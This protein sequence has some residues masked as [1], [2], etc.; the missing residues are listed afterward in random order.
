M[1]ENG[2]IGD[3][4]RAG[5]ETMRSAH[6]TPLERKRDTVGALAIVFLV[7]WFALQI[8]DAL[9]G[10]IF[11]LIPGPLGGLTQMAYHVSFAVYWFC[12]AWW[13]Y[14]DCKVRDLNAAA[15]GL[16]T[17]AT[18]FIGFFTYLVVRAPAARP[19]SACGRDLLPG[20]KVCPYCGTQVTDVCP[21]CGAFVR[22]DWRFCPSC[23]ANMNGYARRSRDLH[24]AADDLRAAGR[25]A[26]KAASDAA[27][28]GVTV[29][30]AGFQAAK[31]TYQ[32]ISAERAPSRDSISG[33]VTD[34][35]TGRPIAGARVWIDSKELERSATTGL[36]GDYRLF[37]LE[38]GPYVVVA[39]AAGYRRVVGSCEV[40]G[41]ACTPLD[42]RLAKAPPEPSSEA[43]PGQEGT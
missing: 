38:P 37:G 9:P 15:W 19:C 12:L 27:E 21:E 30:R 2:G 16:L 28:I 25:K 10:D 42:F 29:A 1:S 20:Q 8:L 4:L 5:L 43:A 7:I 22:G 13:V 6:K 36:S 24:G 26:A 3:D 32:Q 40:S 18:N 39:E 23:S 14:L 17:L 11:R 41:G 33:T 34:S 31:E 35:A